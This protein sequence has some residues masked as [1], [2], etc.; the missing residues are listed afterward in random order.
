MHQKCV[1]SAGGLKV[2]SLSVPLSS[3][4]V[5]SNFSVK[6][7]YYKNPVLFDKSYVISS[8][9]GSQFRRIAGLLLIRARLASLQGEQCIRRDVVLLDSLLV[10]SWFKRIQPFPCV[11]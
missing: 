1:P 5:F 11:L 9:A 2:S 10:L 8:F 7:F 3:S 4:V 6:L